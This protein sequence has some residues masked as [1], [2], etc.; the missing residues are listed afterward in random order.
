ML[1]LLKVQELKTTPLRECEQSVVSLLSNC[2]KVCAITPINY[3][4]HS[5]FNH[6]VILTSNHVAVLNQRIN[7]ICHTHPTSL[8]NIIRSHVKS[9]FQVSFS[10]FHDKGFHAFVQPF[11][12]ATR[13]Y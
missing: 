4:A 12:S 1:K 6:L 2:R 9:N 10:T 3:R 7:I 11:S 8:D 5:H 13:P